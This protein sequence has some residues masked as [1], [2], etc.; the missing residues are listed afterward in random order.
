MSD[1]LERR[2]GRQP[3]PI[4]IGRLV[5]GQYRYLIQESGQGDVD[6]YYVNPQRDSLI[7]SQQTRGLAAETT[8]TFENVDATKV[9][10]VQLGSIPPTLTWK[11]RA[12]GIAEPTLTY[13]TKRVV[14]KQSFD[15]AISPSELK[16]LFFKKP[17]NEPSASFVRVN[18]TS[19]ELIGIAFRRDFPILLMQ[20]PLPDGSTG[21]SS[22]V[23]LQQFL[24]TIYTGLTKKLSDMQ[25]D[26]NEKVLLAFSSG[27]EITMLG[28]ASTQRTRRQQEINKRI[29]QIQTMLLTIEAQ[30]KDGLANADL[31]AHAPFLRDLGKPVQKGT[32]FSRFHIDDP[33]PLPKLSIDNTTWTR[34]LSDPKGDVLATRA[35]QGSFSPPD[36]VQS[37]PVTPSVP[38]TV[39]AAREQTSIPPR[40]E[41]VLTEKQQAI[42]LAQE[43]DTTIGTTLDAYATTPLP[44]IGVGVTADLNKRIDKLV[45]HARTYTAQRR[46][47]RNPDTVVVT[48][49][50]PQTEISTIGDIPKSRIF[51]FLT[52]GEEVEYKDKIEKAFSVWEKYIRPLYFYAGS[53]SERTFRGIKETGVIRTQAPDTAEKLVTE[54]EKLLRHIPSETIHVAEA[55]QVL[56]SVQI[57][58][59]LQQHYQRLKADGESIEIDN[60]ASYALTTVSRMKNL[61]HDLTKPRTE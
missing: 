29:Y 39:S 8:S 45:A 26:V 56:L 1:A 37:A 52:G 44:T 9:K 15:V 23:A 60:W 6:Y 42:A 41:R 18:T 25:W 27:G 47:G 46:R 59:A 7:Y 53:R 24:D 2:E 61:M 4:T 19:R 49:V 43:L 36:F 51:T 48:K 50:S 38:H 28:D 10:V 35:A 22:Q 55:S 33:K 30:G 17:G 34:L 21:V 54:F 40:P 31:L 58:S 16:D 20:N 57:L 14:T 3:A 13:P 11:E 32:I 12:D 5:I